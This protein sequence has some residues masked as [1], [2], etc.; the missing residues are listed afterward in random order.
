MAFKVVVEPLDQQNIWFGS[1]NYGDHSID[2]IIAFDDITQQKPRAFARK[3]CVER[4]EPDS[5]L[6][7]SCRP[8]RYQAG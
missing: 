1:R 7:N 2:L 8:E 3:F 4:R 6:S 5:V